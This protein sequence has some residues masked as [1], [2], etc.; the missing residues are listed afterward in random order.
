MFDLSTVALKD[1]KN[2]FDPGRLQ[3]SFEAYL[4]AIAPSVS[5]KSEAPNLGGPNVFKIIAN[6]FKVSPQRAGADATDDAPAIPKNRLGHIACD[7]LNAGDSWDYYHYFETEDSAR[8]FFKTC[9]ATNVGTG[10]LVN[11]HR[12]DA[13][14]AV[15]ETVHSYHGSSGRFDWFMNEGFTDW[16]AVDFAE[17][18]FGRA[19]PYSGGALYTPARRTAGRIIEHCGREVVAGYFFSDDRHGAFERFAKEFSKGLMLMAQYTSVPEEFLAEYGV[20]P[21]PLRPK[22]VAEGA[23]ALLDSTQKKKKAAMARARAKVA[24]PST[25]GMPPPPPPP[26]GT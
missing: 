22:R 17:S 3:I 1:V 2:R 23:D 10:I 24:G 8:G 16:F 11:G 4:A 7:V 12:K 26:P 15:H 25:G 13:S 6:P 5:V 19:F 9:G 14:D 20:P 18:E 21:L